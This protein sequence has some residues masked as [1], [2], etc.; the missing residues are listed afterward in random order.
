MILVI[1]FLGAIFWFF[2]MLFIFYIMQ[3]PEVQVRRR[4]HILIQNAELER[5]KVAGKTKKFLSKKK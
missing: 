5:L 2:F 3:R 1:S 4:L